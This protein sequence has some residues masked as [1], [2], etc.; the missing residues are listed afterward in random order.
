MYKLDPYPNKSKTIKDKVP[1]VTQLLLLLLFLYG[2]VYSHYLVL[3]LKRK[4][5]PEPYFKN[6]I[7]KTLLLFQGGLN[8]LVA[9]GIVC[10]DPPP[11]WITDLPTAG[12]NKF[13]LVSAGRRDDNWELQSLASTIVDHTAIN[14]REQS[15]L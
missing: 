3:I 2:L 1:I 14:L 8:E 13:S 10:N 9:A 15:S 4:S 5:N 6:A 11:R 7:L 12:R